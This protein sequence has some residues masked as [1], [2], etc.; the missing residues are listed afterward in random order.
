MV[1]SMTAYGR[2]TLNTEWGTLTAEMQSVNRRH[3]EINTSLP[4][5]WMVFDPL[6]KKRIQ[7]HLFRGKVSLHLTYTLNEKSQVRKFIPDLLLAKELQQGWSEL[8]KHLELK[9]TN[10]TLISL[11][12]REPSLFR[13]EL[14]QSFVTSIQSEVES[15]VEA[16]LKKLQKMRSDEGYF[17]KQ[18]LLER[19][20]N[21]EALLK[22]SQDLGKGASLYLQEKILIRVG[23]LL[24]SSLTEDERLFK[25]VAFLADKGD[26]SEEL[27][28]IESHLILFKSVLEKQ[29]ESLGKTL[30][31]IS[32]ELNRE[33]NTIGSKC[34]NHQLSH[35]VI[36]AKSECEK[37]REQVQNIE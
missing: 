4:K 33:W 15:V 36:E 5:E 13:S 10:E 27:T 23:E 19:I 34:A 12:S 28:R 14:S 11:L 18:E 26:L 32:Q 17:L 2:V 22:K 21:L 8:S 3:L 7:K 1:S 6:L 35:L 16:A 25:E 9:V 31:F 20:T 29:G 37:I 30:D 24:K